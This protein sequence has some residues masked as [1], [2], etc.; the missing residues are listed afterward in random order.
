MRMAVRQVTGGSIEGPVLRSA[1]IRGPGAPGVGRGRTPDA[2]IQGERENPPDSSSEGL[3]PASASSRAS[4]I[5]P[6]RSSG[7]KCA[8]QP[9][10]SAPIRSASPRQKLPRDRTRPEARHRRSRA[11]FSLLFPV[12]ALLLGSALPAAAQT[13]VWSATLSVKELSRPPFFGLYGCAGPYDENL[14]SALLTDTTFTHDGVEYTVE[15][16]YVL[17]TESLGLRLDKP[18]AEGVRELTLHVDSRQF[19]FPDAAAYFEQGTGVRWRTPKL[20]WAANQQVTLS[21]RTAGP[22]MQLGSPPQTSAPQRV[23][24]T[25]SFEQVPVEHDGT[26]FVFLVRLS[27]ALG[28]GAQAP[29]AG[30]FAVAGG[31]V[32]KVRPLE[33]GLWRVRIK[34]GS[35]RRNVRVTLPGGRECDAVG[36][37]C[38]ADGRALS[39]AVSVKVPGPARLTVKGGKAREGKDA[40]IDFAVTLSRAVAGPVTVDYATADGTATAGEDY[41]ATSGALTFAPGE[42]GKTVSVAVLDDAHDEGRERFTLHL[43]NAS[44]ARIAHGKATGTI[45]NADPLQQAWLGRFGRAAASDAVAAV[46]ARFETP[47]G[48]GSHLTLAGQRLSGED[49]GLA[50]AVMGLARAFG[51]EEEAAATGDP[52][53]DPASAPARSMGTRELLMG[54][55]FRAVLGQGAGS[56]LT[57]WGQG[58]SVSEFSGAAPGLALSGE[59]A[60]GAFGMDYERG[61]LLAGFAMTH[62]LGEGTAHGAGRIYAMGSAVTTMLPYARFAISERI[63]AWGLAGTGSG[64]LTLDLD[65]AAAKRYRTDLS[66]T[67]AAA[68]VRGE[69]VTPAEPGG[70]ALALKAD[71]FWVRTESDA[72]S[73]PGVGNLAAARADASRLRAVLDGKRTFALAGGA[74]L[75]P[76]FELGVRLDGGDAETGAGTE[77]GAGL[78]YADLSRG[79]DMALRVHGL[80]GHAEDGYREWGVSGSLRLVP[81][82]AERGFSMSLTPSWGAD[83]GGSER[84]W[85]LPYASGLAANGDAPAS[86]RLDT[87]F[88]YGLAMFGGGFTG[89]PNV[90]FGLSDAAR[91]L[92]MGWRLTPAAPDGPSFELSLDATRRESADGDAPEHGVMLRALTRW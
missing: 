75:T 44:G 25:A 43:S 91:E 55:S 33:P 51:A 15:D 1:R 5:E 45:R 17:N 21:L 46:T 76:S 77:F 27:E 48:A 87:E 82:A 11:R 3:T 23:A 81:G 59:S 37:V 72:V 30:S 57:S 35:W 9:A 40:S 32:K 36:A 63:S 8:R 12:L 78:S 79:V 62:S 73:A 4:C 80:A 68:G 10:P 69:L 71:A 74:A 65:A 39:N 54:T 84:L 41:T 42:T 64:G 26:G 2:G 89:T 6:K 86:S 20:T 83:P 70:F 47:R 18:L 7:M 24:L 50:Q 66:M 38:A 52:W 31:K 22:E 28:A 88:G 58:A 92:R 14:Y 19:T 29:T 53:N 56:Q 34:P 49:A 85:T 16:V 61:S 67:L 60:T 13:T 90:G